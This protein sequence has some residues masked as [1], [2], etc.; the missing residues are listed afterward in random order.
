MTVGARTTVPPN[1]WPMHWWPR[2][3]PRMGFTPAKLL[4]HGVADARVVGAAG[5]RRDQHRVGIELDDLVQCE[6]VVTVHDR[7]GAELTEVLHQ[8]EHER[9]VVVDHQD[10]GRH[11][12][13][14]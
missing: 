5:P 7:V 3:T 10:W 9:V 13:G 12:A 11:G 6:L 2:H 4:D 1:T 8:V 14:G